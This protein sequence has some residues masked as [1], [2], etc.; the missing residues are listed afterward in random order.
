MAGK[1]DGDGKVAEGKFTDHL[2]VLM[3][4]PLWWGHRLPD[5]GV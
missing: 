3:K 4:N 2:K 5:A 1:K